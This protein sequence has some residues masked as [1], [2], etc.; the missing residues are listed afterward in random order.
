MFDI[1]TYEKTAMFDLTD[2]E[3][4]SLNALASEI[5]EGFREI[6]KID[7]ANVEP[8]VS[9][10]DLSGVMREDI[11]EKLIP[12]ETIMANAPEHKD[13]YFQVPGTL[14]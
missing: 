7:T 13:G 9:V 3:R 6:E 4:Q 8:L 1:K 11:S 5:A 12:R 10:L 14:E 2:D